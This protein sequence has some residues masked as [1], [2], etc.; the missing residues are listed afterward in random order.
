[1]NRFL[2]LCCVVLSTAAAAPS[3]A[4]VVNDITAAQVMLDRLGFSSG[5]IDGRMGTNVHGALNAF[6]QAKRLP[7][8]GE[9]DSATWQRL[10]EESGAQPPL[11]AYTIADADLAEA[12]TPDIP[13]D[14]MEQSKL[15]ALGYRNVLEALA[16]KFHGSPD[17]L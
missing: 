17:L 1:M 15:K 7:M 13:S 6:Q 4:P 9:L 2:W 10:N 16:E 14:L 3:Q 12:F 8:T 11:M 5:E